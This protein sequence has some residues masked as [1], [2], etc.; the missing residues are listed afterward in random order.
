[1]MIYLYAFMGFFIALMILIPVGVIV[2]LIK[3]F[4]RKEEVK[5]RAG[6]IFIKVNSFI[7]FCS[8]MAVSTMILALVFK[9]PPLS[10]EIEQWIRIAEKLGAPIYL[11]VILWLTFE[12]RLQYRLHSVEQS[13]REDV[14]KRLKEFK[15]DMDKNFS[16]LN[17]RIDRIWATLV[18][19]QSKLG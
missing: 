11:L 12:N 2:F 6:K 8:Y 10:T 9:D 14:G 4:A 7:L 18:Q 19:K 5:E 17:E 13:I 15:E 3:R 1:M 16:Q